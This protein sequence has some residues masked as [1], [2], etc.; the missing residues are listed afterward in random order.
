MSAIGIIVSVITSAFVVF[1]V[2]H[3]V[4][5]RETNWLIDAQTKRLRMLEQE[6]NRLTK[7][8]CWLCE[9]IV[10]EKTHVRQQGS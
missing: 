6:N 10:R 3:Y 8:R 9:S 4:G 5:Y 1:L 7:R 2:G